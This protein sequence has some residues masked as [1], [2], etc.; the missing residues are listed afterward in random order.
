[1]EDA[2]EDAQLRGDMLRLHGKDFIEKYYR[3]I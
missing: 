2:G 1:M 3:V